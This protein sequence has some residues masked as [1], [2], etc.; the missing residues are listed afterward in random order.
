MRKYTVI[1]D[2]MEFLL[3]AVTS[4]ALDK[5]R[6]FLKLL[7]SF[8]LEMGHASGKSF[9]HSVLSALDHLSQFCQL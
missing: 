6:V 4:S 3:V 5:L 2:F 1:D 7:I 8:V 9:T